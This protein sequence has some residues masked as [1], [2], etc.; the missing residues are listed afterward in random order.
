MSN[1]ASL[2]NFSKIFD[3]IVV[4]LI[5]Q[6]KNEVDIQF[7]DKVNLKVKE[8]EEAC[9]A[10]EA[11]Y[12]KKKKELK[13]LFY[14]EKYSEKEDDKFLFDVHK[15][16][17]IVCY[18]LIKHK[19]F[20]F[21][22]KVACEMMDGKETSWVIDNAFINYK[23]AFYV[24]VSIIYYKMFFE[25]EEAI[26]KAIEEGT[27]KDAEEELKHS[28]LEK[29]KLFLYKIRTGHESFA[30]SIILDFAKRDIH[31]RSFDYF[32][33]SALLFQLEEYNKIYFK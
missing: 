29:R 8:R 21:D 3:K 13:R 5:E 16:A 24:S 4:P 31:K 33:Y 27:N 28:L 15:V 17:S 14:G 23:L 26:K 22:E 19:V 12:E 9:S 18:S 20:V 32:L 11:F 30:N 2:S 10:C 1:Q 25:V 7:K 6:V